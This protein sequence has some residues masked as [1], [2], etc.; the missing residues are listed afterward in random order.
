MVL[1][2]VH[3][4]QRWVVSNK[5]GLRNSRHLPKEFQPIDGRNDTKNPAPRSNL[6]LITDILLVCTLGKSIIAGWTNMAWIAQQ[7]HHNDIWLGEISVYLQTFFYWFFKTTMPMLFIWLFAN[8]MLGW[9]YLSETE[10]PAEYG[11]VDTDYKFAEFLLIPTMFCMLV[12]TYNDP[13]CILTTAF[14]HT[15][16]WTVNTTRCG[17]VEQNGMNVTEPPGF[18][19]AQP[20]AY[21]TWGSCFYSML[22]RVVYHCFALTALAYLWHFQLED[23]HLCERLLNIYFWTQVMC[24][25][26]YC[27]LVYVVLNAASFQDPVHIGGMIHTVAISLNT[28]PYIWMCLKEW[29]HKK[30]H[31]PPL[32]SIFLKTRLQ[33][34][35]KVVLSNMFL[36]GIQAGFHNGRFV[37]EQGNYEMNPQRNL[38]PFASTLLVWG[39]KMLYFDAANGSNTHPLSPNKHAVDFGYFRAILWMFLQLLAVPCAGLVAQGLVAMI[40]PD[41]VP[42]YKMKLEGV[43][44]ALLLLTLAGLTIV[45]KSAGDTR[46]RQRRR[47]FLR[48]FLSLVIF[49][50]TFANPIG[51]L[52]VWLTIFGLPALGLLERVLDRRC[53]S[54]SLATLLFGLCFE[55]PMARQKSVESV[56]SG[57]GGENSTPLLGDPEGPEIWHIA[58]M[59]HFAPKDGK[60]LEDAEYHM[61]RYV[62][63]ESDAAVVV[64]GD[65]AI[66]N[67]DMSGGDADMGGF[68]L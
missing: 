7:E 32:D 66:D 37:N 57:A 31:C 63:G 15:P 17:H 24:L 46:L 26:C 50:I 38:L 28:L 14:P 65:E 68:D 64:T 67:F 59:A 2:T 55:I 29:I 62:E 56:K 34:V 10:M 35:F 42:M 20:C 19:P 6:L 41:D 60:D 5:R 9:F 1:P 4:R 11:G 27:V 36:V 53:S 45:H 30:H 22:A 44:V 8:L 43:A 54:V 52:T 33:T 49:I 21:L 61:V 48:C 16:S 3:L 47:F 18:F 25:C 51:E 13:V 40:G 12:A 39:T 23:L 58:D